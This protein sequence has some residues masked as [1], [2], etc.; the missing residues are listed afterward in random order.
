M[1][2]RKE[3]NGMADERGDGKGK[4]DMYGGD[5]EGRKDRIT[6]MEEKT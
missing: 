1:I 5:M 2:K 4:T 3:L 6:Y